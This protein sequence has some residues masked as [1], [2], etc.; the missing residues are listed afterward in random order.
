[1]KSK[2]S[3]RFWCALT[4]F[5][6]IGQ[7]AWVVENMYF[8]VFIYHMFRASASDI[9]LMVAASAVAAT[10]TTVL[11]GA[12]SDRIGKRKLFI[13]GGYVLWGLS[14]LSFTL[15][16]QDILHA[17]LVD[18]ADEMRMRGTL[19]LHRLQ[20]AVFE[21]GHASLL[22]HHVHDDRFLDVTSLQSQS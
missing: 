5:A 13:C 7:V 18:V 15:L 8:N 11:M 20:L 21:Q 22:R 19:H 12:L 17:P 2:M 6:L 1:M 9:S 14:I 4:L 3:P 10:L 16:R